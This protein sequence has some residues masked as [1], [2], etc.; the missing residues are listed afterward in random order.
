MNRFALIVI[1]LLLVPNANASG[2][3][4]PLFG[5]DLPGF[6]GNSAQMEKLRHADRENLEADSEYPLGN[7][8][9]PLEG[10]PQ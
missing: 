6:F 7:A 4:R 2:R 8:C 9:V 5:I 1:F 10:A 3:N